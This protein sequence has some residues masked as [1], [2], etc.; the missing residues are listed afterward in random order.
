MRKRLKII[1]VLLT[2]VFL[3]F[4][5]LISSICFS[6]T[7]LLDTPDTPKRSDAIVILAGNI[8]RAIY[9]ANLYRQGYA[10]KIYIS[11]PIVPKEQILLR[12]LNI[13][14]PRE[15]ELNK[16]ILLKKGVS[17]KD[18]FIFG[19]SSM[20]TIEEAE[21]LKKTFKVGNYNLLIIVSPYSV[22]RVKMIFK[23]KIKNCGII[24]VPN[25]YENSSRRWW[26]IK[27]SAEEVIL[28]LPKILFYKLGGSFHS[29][30]SEP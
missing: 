10:P 13:T 4:I 11:R 16:E 18:I 19:K 30:Q 8:T 22:R 3:L 20:S 29:P 15:E 25:T 1:T 7:W 9:A 17:D 6:G 14:I 2:T 28:E 23:D 12:E 26:T 27:N 21:E 24:V 5:F